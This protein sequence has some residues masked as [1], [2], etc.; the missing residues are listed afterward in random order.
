VSFKA[1]EDSRF[2]PVFQTN[3]LFLRIE[4]R[5]FRPAAVLIDCQSPK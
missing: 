2:F 1:A 3:R 4:L 5:P